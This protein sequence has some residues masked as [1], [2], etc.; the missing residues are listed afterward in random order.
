MSN[1]HGQMPPVILP[2]L[3][4]SPKADENGAWREAEQ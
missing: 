1:E 3:A 2:T 4:T